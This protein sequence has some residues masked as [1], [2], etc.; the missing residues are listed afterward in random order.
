VSE[1][2]REWR[3]RANKIARANLAKIPEAM[4]LIPH[5]E[6]VSV[7]YNGGGDSGQFEDALAQNDDDTAAIEWPKATIK[8]QSP[9]SQ[10]NSEKGEWETEIRETEHTISDYFVEAAHY[11]VSI[12][13]AGWENNEGGFGKVI[14]T[15]DNV[16]V[17]HSDHIVTVEEHFH[18]LAFDD[19]SSEDVG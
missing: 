11:A 10:W 7:E 17:E 5:V 15:K 8:V 14:F 13:H 3:E 16:R 2:Y 18:S 19:E 6:K 1:S 4:A 9:V 12:W